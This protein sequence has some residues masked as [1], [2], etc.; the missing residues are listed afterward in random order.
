MFTSH[1]KYVPNSVPNIAGALLPFC[2]GKYADRYAGIYTDDCNL[3]YKL[4]IKQ[5]L[6]LL[7]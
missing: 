4:F 6:S 2:A 1:P 7:N 3:S 5:R